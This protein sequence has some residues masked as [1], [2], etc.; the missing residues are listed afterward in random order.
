MGKIVALIP[1][2]GG[3][4]CVPKKNLQKINGKSLLSH[5]ISSAQASYIDEVFVSSDSTEILDEAID[6]GS[7]CIERPANISGDLN[8]T[9]EAIEHFVQHV[10]CDI[11]V[12]IQATSPM[13]QPTDINA[14]LH[15]YKTGKYGSVLSLSGPEHLSL[16]R[17]DEDLIEPFNYDPTHRK[18]RQQE[19]GPHYLIENGAFY[20]FSK[21]DFLQHK[22]RIIPKVGYVRMDFWRSFE[23]DS[24]SDLRNI[25]ILMKGQ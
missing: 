18:M 17:V 25:E 9:E 22:C 6:F 5:A 20:I 24:L 12:L 3:S 8:T 21:K 15:K 11:V 2:R 23:V 7:R 19:N 14:G 16:W 4:K 10:D 13:V 1:A